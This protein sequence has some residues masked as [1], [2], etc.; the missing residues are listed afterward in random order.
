MEARWD[1]GMGKRGAE[2]GAG[3]QGREVWEAS[4]PSGS[5]R[6]WSWPTGV[7]T[8]GFNVWRGRKLGVGLLE[9]GGWGQSDQPCH[10]TRAL[11]L[12]GVPSCLQD[13]QP[14]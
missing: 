1:A 11:P 10:P 4:L 13:T 6:A 9:G 12:S 2:G 3:T 8:A 5:M 14:Q 7:S